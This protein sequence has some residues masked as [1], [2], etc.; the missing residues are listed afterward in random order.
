MLGRQVFRME[1]GQWK[2]V[3]DPSVYQRILDAKGLNVRAQDLKQDDYFAERMFE[4][5]GF[6]KVESLDYSDYQGATLVWDLNRP[7]PEEWH[8]QFGFIFDGGTLE[9]VFDVPQAFKNVF[10]LLNEGGVFAAEN[11][12][13]GFPSHGM[14]QFSPELIWTYWKNSC[15]CD[16]RVCHALARKGKYVRDLPD[17]TEIGGRIPIKFG[18]VWCGRLP[19]GRVTLWYEVQKKATSHLPQDVLQSDYVSTWTDTASRKGEVVK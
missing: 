13:N 17:P 16:V 3:T 6:G 19:Y 2:G 8:G 7:V 15:N 5:I 1:H 9:H 4:G 14:Y 12:F 10:N 11:P 18:P